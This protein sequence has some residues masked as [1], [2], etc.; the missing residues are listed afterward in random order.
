MVKRSSKSY[1]FKRIGDFK[2]MVK[3]IPPGMVA[4]SWWRDGNVTVVAPLQT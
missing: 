1:G 2:A 4:L 3:A